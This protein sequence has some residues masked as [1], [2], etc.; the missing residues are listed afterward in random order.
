MSVKSQTNK[1]NGKDLIN[2]GVYA[3]IYVVIVWA[4]A[5]L[6]FIPIFMPLLSVFVP[7]LGGVPFMLFL[8]KVKKP[9]MIFIMTMIMGIMMLFTGMGHY[10]LIVGVFSGIAAELIYKS[11]KYQSI[12][13]GILSYGIFSVWMWG[14]Y[15]PL[16]WDAEGY[17]AT[18]QS[19]GPE[20]VETLS[21]LMQVWMCPVLFVVCIVCGIIGG[22]IGKALLKKHFK[23]AGIA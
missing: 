5:M 14:N 3:A 7:L 6:G 21:N 13:K 22:C 8:T 2:I 18:R 12:K 23:K 10:S 9:G 11:G 16:F 1:L 19:Y 15:W 4:V 20:Y 17:F